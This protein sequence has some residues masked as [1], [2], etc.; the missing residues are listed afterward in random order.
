MGASSTT[1]WRD[2]CRRDGIGKNSTVNFL[3]RRYTNTNRQVLTWPHQT[4]LDYSKMLHGP[5]LLVC[6]ATVM[7]QWIREFH[8]WWP[9]FRVFLLRT[10]VSM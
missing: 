6:P 7:N 8:T 3:F 2:Y 9:P 1:V 10:L 5:T 4:G